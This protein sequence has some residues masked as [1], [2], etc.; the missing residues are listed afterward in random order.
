MNSIYNFFTSR[1]ILSVYGTYVH[2]YV[3]PLIHMLKKFTQQMCDQKLPMRCVTVRYCTVRYRNLVGYRIFLLGVDFFYRTST[4]T[5]QGTYNW[6]CTLP[7]MGE[8][9]FSRF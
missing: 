1:L 5:V 6:Y 4:G 2:R 9:R 3:G 8:F 7:G